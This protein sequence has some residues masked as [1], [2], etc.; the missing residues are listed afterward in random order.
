MLDADLIAYLQ[1]LTNVPVEMN[2][3][4]EGV[5]YPAVFV[6]R[7]PSQHALLL[8]GAPTVAEDN[9][10]VECYGKDI[11]AVENVAA[12]VL[13]GLNGYKGLMGGSFILAAFVSDSADDYQ[14]R[15]LLSTDEGFHVSSMDV[16]ILN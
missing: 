14:S 7:R 6:Q 9:Y 4:S 11:D 10:V 16:Q 1:G 13:A 15:V 12:T 2:K 5:S 3:I 8:N